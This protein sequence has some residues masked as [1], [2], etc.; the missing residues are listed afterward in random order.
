[1]HILELSK[2]PDFVSEIN[3]LISICV[4]QIPFLH[5]LCVQQ[6]EL[7]RTRPDWSTSKMARKVN[8][9]MREKTNNLGS[10]Q[11]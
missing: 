5:S 9:P 3:S 7:I 1:M 4:F 10:N 11:V 6:P 2:F 8:E